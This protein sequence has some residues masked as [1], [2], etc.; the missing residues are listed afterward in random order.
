MFLGRRRGFVCRSLDGKALRQG[1]GRN[2]AGRPDTWE[3]LSQ[4]ITPS[5]RLAEQSLQYEKQRT[6][7]ALSLARSQES[8]LDVVSVSLARAFFCAR[9][10]VG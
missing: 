2:R 9:P 4:D 1:I 8:F 10:V 6:A 7:D 3:N 5:K